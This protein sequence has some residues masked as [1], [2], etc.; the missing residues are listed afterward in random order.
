M[1]Y[2]DVEEMAAMTSKQASVGA[3]EPGTWHELQA[4]QFIH[5][6]RF[7]REISRLSIQDRLKHMTLH[8]A[9]YAGELL[10]IEPRRAENEVLIDTFII[11]I[12]SAN[13]LGID[14]ERVDLSKASCP[15]VSF[16]QRLCVAAGKMAAACEKLDHLEA[17]PF[18]ETMGEW[19]VKI[20]SDAKNEAGS[21]GLL[22]F[23]AVASR[24]DEV[25]RKNLFYAELHS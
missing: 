12:S 9:K 24:L 5:D 7:H 8:F 1:G 21:R 20:I 19:V 2:Y 13:I 10:S 16:G 14:L 15:N 4:A 6:E 23:E 3:T 11:A 17:F 18:R 22:L 25:K